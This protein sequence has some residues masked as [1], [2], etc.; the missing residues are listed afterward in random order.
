MKLT[1]HEKTILELIRKHPDIVDNPS[2]R[3]LVAHQYGFKE[4]TLRN[5]IGDLKKYG[6]LD[7]LLLRINPIQSIESDSG[8][9]EISIPLLFRMFWNDRYFII[10]NVFI[11]SILAVILALIMPKTFRSTVVLMHPSSDDHSGILGALSQ[12]MPFGNLFQSPKDESMDFMAILKSRTVMESVIHEF[13]LIDFYHSENVEKALETLGENVNIELQEEGTIKA[14]VNVST[15]WF[16][17][18]EEEINA[19]Q[20]CASM[21]NYFIERLDAVNKGLKTERASF[22]RLFI[23]K[24]YQQNM[25]DLQNAEEDFKMFQEEH[26]MISL[27]EQTN[28]A[29]QAAATIK[30]QQLASEVQLGVLSKTLNPNHPDVIRLNNEIQGLRMKL[31]EMDIGYNIADQNKLFP[32]FSQVPELGVQLMR[33]TREV[34]IQNTLFTFLT[35]QYEDAKIQEAKNTPTVQVLDMGKIPEIKYKPA[36]VRIVIIGFAFSLVFSMYYLHFV[37]RWKKINPK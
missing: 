19:R 3:K 34:E 14:S 7:D 25:V 15:G 37:N 36:R 30:A 5:R 23:E 2:A 17:R 21:A 31:K 9:D 27:P 8:N 26:K 6:A 16:H 24:R 13:G 35:Q 29:I 1:P 33:L 18:E 10:R 28:A 12:Q 11:V 20:M 32:V 4:K 22:H